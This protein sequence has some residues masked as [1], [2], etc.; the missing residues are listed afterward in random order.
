MDYVKL[1]NTTG[2]FRDPQT[3]LTVVRSELAELREPVGAL[4]RQ[5]LIA[6]GLVRVNRRPAPD[7]APSAGD[8]GHSSTVVASSSPQDEDNPEPTEAEPTEVEEAPPESE[9][10]EKMSEEELRTMPMGALR[11]IAK[12]LGVKLQRTDNSESIVAKILEAQG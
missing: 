7:F 6:G 9:E 8:D 1:K 11:K 4:T 3:G 5:W 2:S 10:D 12:G